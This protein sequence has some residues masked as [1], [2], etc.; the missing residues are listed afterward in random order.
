MAE[1]WLAVGGYRGSG[2]H[3]RRRRR[4]LIRRILQWAFGLLALAGVVIF[5]SILARNANIG[6]N[7]GGRIVPHAPVRNQP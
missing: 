4:K 7:P 6:V 3:G 5:G 1:D 2:S